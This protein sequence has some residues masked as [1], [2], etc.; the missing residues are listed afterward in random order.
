MTNQQIAKILE[1]IASILEIQGDMVFKIRAYQRAAETVSNLPQEV[2]KLNEKELTELPGIGPGI[3]KKIYSLTTTGKSDYYDELRKSE[4]AP[5]VDLLQIPSIGPKHARQLYDKLG[6]KSVSDLEKAA[7]AGKIK[8][9]PGMGA[10]SEENMLKGISALF[11]HKERIPLGQILPKAE[12]LVA[13]LK[14]VK[15]VKEIA[16]AGSLRRMKETIADGDI[17]VSSTRPQPVMN[18]FTNLPE[19][20]RVLSHG[21]TKSSII[22]KDNFQV[23]LRVVKPESW[24]AALH[25]FTGSKSHNVKVRTLAVKK[26]LSV[27]EY[28]LWKGRKSIASRTEE[29]MYKKLGMQWVPPEIRED[30][31]E[32]ELAFK[33][34]IPRLIEAGD[35]KG[36][37]QMHTDWSDGN[38]T[39]QEMAQAA[40][41]LGYQYI[42]ITDHSSLVGITQGLDVK[43]VKKQI[44]EIERI[45]RKLKVFRILSGIEVDIKADGTLDLPDEALE[46]LDLV[47]ATV[48]TRFNLPS[49]QMTKRIIRA[50]ENPHVDILGH[51]TG[52]LIGRRDPYQVDLDRVLKAA[53]TNKKV[54]ELNCSPDRL[55]LPDIWVRKAKD[56]EIK[57]SI[58]TD[59]HRTG[60]LQDWMRYGIGCGRRGWLEKK[61]VVNCLPLDKFLKFFKIKP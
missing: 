32:V 11:R 34:K 55:D 21:S 60:H 44:E 45:N 61:D 36:D 48:H 59:S 6:V 2:S 5:L 51:P 17:L 27:N 25:Y 58:A 22:T 26:K 15:E 12:Q 7:K 47:V 19:V 30:W 54:L 40:Q 43:R 46:Q 53:L 23:D 9:L 13:Q 50:L 8:N 39:I 4:Y 20:A 14:K 37:L 56:M 38:S 33:N 28:G 24:G 3:A 1:E 35:I 41:K 52:R 16:L 31:G 42:A 49:D 10:K 29:D 57:I 18:A